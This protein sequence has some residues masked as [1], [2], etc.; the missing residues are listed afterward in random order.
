[1]ISCVNAD[2][3]LQLQ[4]ETMVIVRGI[5][6]TSMALVFISLLH[7]IPPTTTRPDKSEFQLAGCIFVFVLQLT[8]YECTHGAT[9]TATATD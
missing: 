3:F 9:M 7:L 8:S 5:F 4:M 6:T 1:M 2:L